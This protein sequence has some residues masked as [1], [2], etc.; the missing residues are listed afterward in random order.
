MV[1]FVIKIKDRDDVQRPRKYFN[2]TSGGLPIPSPG[3]MSRGVS[4]RIGI[5]GRFIKP[6]APRHL[7]RFCHHRSLL[8]SA[9]T[10]DSS[11]IWPRR[12]YEFH[13]IHQVFLQDW[14]VA[15]GCG[16]A[17]ISKHVVGRHFILIEE[18]SG[19]QILLLKV[20]TRNLSTAW[21]YGF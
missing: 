21:N 11:N 6:N 2:D 12:A 9:E 13:L 18:D 17:E 7:L 4:R 20:L 15:G 5:A 3:V 8:E 16:L 1:C 10:A 14:S 19:R